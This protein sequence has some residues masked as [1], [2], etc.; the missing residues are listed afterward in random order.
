MIERTFVMLKPDAVGRRLCGHII[1][2]YEAKGLKLVAM[3]LIVVDRALAAKHYSE[4]KGKSFYEPLVEF[5]TS[6][7]CI[8][9][10]WEGQDAVASVRKINGVTNCTDAEVGTIRGD[11]G[12]N[13]RNNLVH[14]SDSV[15]TAQREIALFFR[16][17]EIWQ[18]NM[19][20]WH[21]LIKT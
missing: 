10:V 20:D 9:M 21:W 14:A 6:G 8:P 3:K 1:S 17:E 15:E 12:L 16:P 13:V 7:P 19:P 5:I 18:H 2:R 11:L 4:H